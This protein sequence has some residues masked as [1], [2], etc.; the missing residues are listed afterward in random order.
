LNLFIQVFKVKKKHNK[1]CIR[2][3]KFKPINK[4][5]N[6]PMTCAMKEMSKNSLKMNF[7]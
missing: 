1:K 6:L 3:Q 4:G 2:K 7:N 5:K